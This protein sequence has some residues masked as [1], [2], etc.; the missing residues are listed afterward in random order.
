MWGLGLEPARAWGLGAR[1]AQTWREK[2]SMAG[3][4]MEGSSNMGIFELM[5]EPVGDVDGVEV[6]VQLPPLAL[7]YRNVQRFRG[8]LVFNAHRLLYH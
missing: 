8:G 7:L 6:A 5:F 3:S 2:G 4:E 1:E